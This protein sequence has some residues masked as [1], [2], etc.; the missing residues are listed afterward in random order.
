MTGIMCHRYSAIT[1]LFATPRILGHAPRASARLSSGTIAN[2]TP[3]CT[4][5]SASSAADGGAEF[6]TR[7]PGTPIIA[8]G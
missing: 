7:S 2:N 4:V 8:T 5:A 3:I 6:S 1:L